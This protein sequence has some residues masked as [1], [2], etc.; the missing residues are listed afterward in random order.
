MKMYACDASASAMPHDAR[1]SGDETVIG[2]SVYFLSTRDVSRQRRP[3]LRIA[4]I[5]ISSVLATEARCS[6]ANGKIQHT[7]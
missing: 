4:V 3:V 2:K 6:A 5:A 7:C 1:V